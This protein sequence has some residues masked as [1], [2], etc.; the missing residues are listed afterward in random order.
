MLELSLTSV[1]H[2]DDVLVVMELS[3]VLRVLV[4]HATVDDDPED[5]DV[6]VGGDAD[7]V[8]LARGPGRVVAVGLLSQQSV[9]PHRTNPPLR[10]HP[11]LVPAGTIMTEKSTQI[12][13]KYFLTL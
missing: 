6:G 7:G 2:E 4:H 12:Y 1:V 13:S 3:S 8:P 5:V 10:T 11:V 9:S